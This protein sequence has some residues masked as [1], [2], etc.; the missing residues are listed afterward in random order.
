[1]IIIIIIVPLS[2]LHSEKKK[3]NQIFYNYQVNRYKLIK[4]K[5]KNTRKYKFT[6]IETVK[7]ADNHMTH[8][9]GL[10][11]RRKRPET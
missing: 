11:A 6:W 2:P 4:F 8:G 9:A 5:T 10:K 1:M 7:R 3:K